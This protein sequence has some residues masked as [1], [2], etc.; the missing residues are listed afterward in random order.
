MGIEPTHPAWRAGS[1]PLTYTRI[2]SGN[3]P[4]RRWPRNA[5]HCVQASW[6]TIHTHN[7]IECSLIAAT[8]FG[9]DEPIEQAATWVFAQNARH[10][11]DHHTVLRLDKMDYNLFR[12]L[13]SVLVTVDRG[14]RDR[15][16]PLTRCMPCSS[17][18]ARSVQAL[19]FC[20][21]ILP[22]RGTLATLG[23]G[24]VQ[25]VYDTRKAYCE[26]CN[27]SGDLHPA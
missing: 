11:T 15:L 24:V 4:D 13:A 16:Q 18:T 5:N 8:M 26:E 7:R 9:G 25:S 3:I 14:R 22:H 10:S 6:G 21:L 17:H 2:K 23:R 19:G 27:A 12:R 20:V 1:L